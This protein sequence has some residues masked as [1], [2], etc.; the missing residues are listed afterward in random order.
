M[1]PARAARPQCKL[2]HW[3]KTRRE[4][5]PGAQQQKVANFQLKLNI[6]SA[7]ITVSWVHA[8]GSALVSFAC[9]MNR[10]DALAQ[11]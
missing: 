10:P 8:S 1:L 5:N 6:S 4:M 2:P 7:L 11:L 9:C 3:S